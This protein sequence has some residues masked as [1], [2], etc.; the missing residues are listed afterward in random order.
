MKTTALLLT[1]PLLLPVARQNAGQPPPR[2][3]NYCR[4]DAT[5]SV[6]C[7]TLPHAIY[8]PDA[9]YPEKERKAGH[10]GTVMLSFVVGTD[11]AAHDIRVA[12]SLSPEFDA[13]AVEC[14][15]TWK[16]S[17]A[18]KNGKPVTAQI[19]IQVDFHLSRHPGRP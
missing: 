19:A 2:A 6:D 11:G 16:F 17:P 15:K 8:A 18:T 13:A 7:T 5:D 12:S 1:L 14:V 10:E 3:S 4:G 9:T